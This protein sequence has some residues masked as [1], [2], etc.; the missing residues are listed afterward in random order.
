MVYFYLIQNGMD[1]RKAKGYGMVEVEQPR[2][3]SAPF[4]F[5]FLRIADIKNSILVD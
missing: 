5:F 2:A 3:L 4:C 1:D